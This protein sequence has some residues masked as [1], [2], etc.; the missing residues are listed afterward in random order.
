MRTLIALFNP[1]RKWL[2]L[3]LLLEF[4]GLVAMFHLAT[5]TRFM[6][7][8]EQV[9]RFFGE[10]MPRS[11]IFALVQ[12]LA[13]TALGL[14]V[15][16]SRE[17]LRGQVVRTVVAFAAGG[18]LMII[19]QYLLPLDPTG[20]GVLFLALVFGFTM[21]VVLRTLLQGLFS[22]RWLRRRILVLGAGERAVHINTQLRRDA[23]RRT[24]QIVGFLGVDGVSEQVPVE[25]R[26]HA[27]GPLHEL[28]RRLNIDEIV[29]APNDRRG[30]LPMD[31]LVE[32]RLRGVR[33]VELSEFFEEETGRITLSAVNPSW[34]VYSSGFNLGLARRVTKRAFDIVVASVVLVL[35]LPVMALTALAIMIESGLR[36]P[37]IYS[38]DRV[39]Q[40]HRHFRVYKFRSMRTDAERDGVAR[41]ATADDDRVTRVGRVIRK[42][43]VDELPQL[44]NVL[45]GDMSFVGPRPERP[46]FVDE[47]SAAIPHYGLRHAIKP[48][49][50]GWAQLRYAYGSSVEDARA[51]LEYDLFYVRNHSLVFDLLVL[52]QTVEVVLFRKGA[53]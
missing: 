48:G 23:D 43:R 10:V 16:Q 28:C 39:T 7:D 26:V 14:Y 6:G 18:V 45:R 15:I 41:W 46:V 50:T 40:G 35:A 25:Q 21:V 13:M 33:I 9:A 17:G 12:I 1:A 32:C 20:R 37:V 2:L 52:L 19:A 30:T 11:I 22:T 27:T 5:W 24:F 51:K 47:L 29:V 8:E 42:L 44:I 3:L 53:R 4:V 49:I 36:S 34:M 38:Q 31:D